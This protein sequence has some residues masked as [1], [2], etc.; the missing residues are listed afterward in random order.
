M[1]RGKRCL[2]KSWN[3]LSNFPKVAVS[4]D[5]TIIVEVAVVNEDIVITKAVVAATDD[6]S[7]LQRVEVNTTNGRAEAVANLLLYG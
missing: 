5:M 3:K 7:D 4:E 2:K 6:I 1:K